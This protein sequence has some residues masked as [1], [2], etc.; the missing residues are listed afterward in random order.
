MN[1]YCNNPTDQINQGEDQ[2]SSIEI[3]FEIEI[4]GQ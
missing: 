2:C 3:C 4:Q 1:N